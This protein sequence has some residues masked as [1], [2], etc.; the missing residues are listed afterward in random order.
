MQIGKQI[1]SCHTTSDTLCIQLTLCQPRASSENE[2]ATTP[3]PT[4]IK[5]HSSA[6]TAFSRLL[7]MLRLAS[8]TSSHF[9][10]GT[11]RMTAE[12]SHFIQT[13]LSELYNRAKR[14]GDVKDKLRNEKAG[15]GLRNATIRFLAGLNLLVRLYF[16]LPSKKYTTISKEEQNILST[17]RMS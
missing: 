3:S 7:R 5:Y 1:L 2:K 10:R 12:I 11:E 8:V 4:W 9:K 6:F 14:P 15:W 16:V 13:L 17:L